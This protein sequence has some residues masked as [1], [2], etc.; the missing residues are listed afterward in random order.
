MKNLNQIIIS[1]T[2]IALLLFSSCKEDDPDPSLSKT[3]LLTASPWSPTE[4]K[5]SGFSGPV[6]AC[7][8]DDV[9]TFSTNGTF[10]FDEG[11]TKCEDEDPQAYSGTWEFNSAETFLI[12]S[13]DGF[14]I[15]KEILELSDIVMKLR[16]NI[17]GVE[18][19]ETFGK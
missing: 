7:T 18:V 11:P 3:E 15:E 8:A 2:I 9:Y 1:F 19:E 17:F 14:T 13:Q 6:D 5:L 10:T 4:V 16:F 12:L